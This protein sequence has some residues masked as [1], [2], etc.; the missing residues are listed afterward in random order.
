MIQRVQARTYAIVEPVS[1]CADENRPV[2]GVI[3][4]A[5]FIEEITGLVFVVDLSI[6]QGLKNP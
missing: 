1:R 3:A 2:V 6:S 5:V 4:I